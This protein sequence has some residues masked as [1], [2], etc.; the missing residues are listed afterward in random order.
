MMRL[1][2]IVIVTAPTRLKGLLVRWGTRGQAKFR[3]NQAISHRS[4]SHSLDDYDEGVAAEADFLQYEE[5]DQN[6]SEVIRTLRNALDF[7]YPVTVL[8]RQYLP[9]FDFRNAILVV[10]VGQDG[11]VANT[12]KY[13]GG[14]PIVG[15]NPDPRRYDGVLLPVSTKQCVRVVQGVIKNQVSLTSVTMASVTLNDGQTM[16]AFNDL[17]VGRRSHVS[18]RYNLKFEAKAETQS[19]SGLIVATGAGSTGWLSSIFNMVKGVNQVLGDRSIQPKKWK[20]SD[21]KLIWAVR[22]PFASKHSQATMVMGEIADGKSLVIESLMPDEGVIFSDGI[23][24]DFLEFNSG[25]LATISVASQ[26]AQL[27]VP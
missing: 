25:S 15:V 27:V 26:Q 17:F 20:L 1:P 7:G 19:S 6:Y 23:E 22:E 14:L 12:A 13:V 3:L 21:R 24:S 5:E 8:E 11:L 2:Q 4:L 16:L 10:V 9:N 18:A